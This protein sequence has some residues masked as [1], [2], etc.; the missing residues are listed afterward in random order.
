MNRKSTFVTSLVMFLTLI[1]VSSSWGAAGTLLWHNNFNFLPEYDMISPS[2][3]FSPTI[4]IVYGQVQKSDYSV[5]PLGFIKVFD[6][7]TG[8]LKWEHSLKLGADDNYLSDIVI[9]GSIIYM[10]SYS[11]SYTSSYDPETHITSRNYTLNRTVFGAYNANTGNPIWENTVD[12]FSG[13]LAA[14]PALPQIN[15]R[16]VI[17]GSENP[18]GF[19][20]SGD[21]IVSV[22]QAKNPDLSAVNNLLLGK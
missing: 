5:A 16:M 17:V 7:S 14:N 2:V 1:L 15:N 13:S 11:S 3:T 10:Q 9:D 8:N 18:S 4:C 19:G 21:C 20:P 12:N 6:M 22:Y